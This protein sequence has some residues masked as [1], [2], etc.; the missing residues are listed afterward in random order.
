MLASIKK[1]ISELS[2][3]KQIIGLAA[4]A[5]S[6]ALGIYLWNKPSKTP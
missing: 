6:I 4:I 2:T 5:S 3:Q 1:N